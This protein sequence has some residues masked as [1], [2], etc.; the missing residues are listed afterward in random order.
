MGNHEP[1]G[2][3]V[4]GQAGPANAAPLPLTGERT[5]P[6]IPEENYWFRRHEI[7]YEYAVAHVGG[8]VLEVGCGEGYGTARLAS[9]AEYVLGVDYDGLTVA[10]AAAT[11]RQARFVRGNLAALPVAGAAVDVLATLQV[12][13]HVWDHGQFVDECF[14]VLRPGGRLLMTT[15]NRLTFSPG[16]D[17]PS[18]P[19]HTVE[20]TA[21]ELVALVERRGFRIDRVCGVHPGSRLTGLDAE[22]GGSFVDAQLL[23]PPDRWS[24]GLRADVASIR[25]DDF[26]VLRGD[27]RNVD[28]SL[29]LV[30]LATRPQR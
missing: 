28:A 4:P 2:I 14:R 6:G 5:V 26:A 18:N 9:A 22:Y 7:A 13:E 23:T 11:Y 21:A 19:F 20:F 10:H 29:D 3:D 24:A 1:R 27:E 17:A 12:I 16:Q 15:P 30:I 25:S 8:R